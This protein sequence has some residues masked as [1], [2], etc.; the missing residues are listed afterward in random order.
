MRCKKKVRK[1]PWKYYRVV[2]PINDTPVICR[3]VKPIKDITILTRP[4]PMTITNRGI[5]DKIEHNK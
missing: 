5:Y 4:I 2:K 1:C 3:V